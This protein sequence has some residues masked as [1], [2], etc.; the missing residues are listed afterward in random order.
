M[1]AAMA[2]FTDRRESACKGALFGGNI[3]ECSGSDCKIEC[4]FLLERKTAKEV[5]TVTKG[6]R[7]TFS[8]CANTP[9][10]GLTRTQCSSKER[11]RGCATALATATASTSGLPTV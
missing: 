6:Y 8:V 3:K 9:D 10:R 1:A 4:S 2:K 7:R 5:V 11:K